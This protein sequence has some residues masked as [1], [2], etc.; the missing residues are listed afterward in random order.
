MN[1]NKLLT[2]I[3][4]ATLATSGI[5]STSEVSVVRAAS[6]QVTSAKQAIRISGQDRYETAAKVAASNWS[7]SDNV[8]LVSGEGYADAIS[9]SVL[10]KKLDA[11]V[12]LTNSKTLNSYAKAALSTLKA[13]NVYVIGGEASISKDVRDALKSTYSITE[14]GGANRYETN[15]AVAGKL[16]DLGVDATNAILVGGQGFSDALTAAS[17]ASSKGEIL[18][19]GSN[20]LSSIKSIENFVNSHKSK[21]TVIGTDLVINDNTYKAVNGANRV[22]G[23]KDRFDTNLKVLESFKS[24]IKGN[25]VYVANASGN[26][27]ADAL[28]ASALAGKNN[29]PLI[30][31]DREGSDATTNAINYLKSSLTSSSDIEVLGGTGVVPEVII[32]KIN[33]SIPSNNNPEPQA[34]LNSIKITSP[35]T[36]LDYTVGD[37]LDITGL[38]V[39]GTYSDNTTKYELIT[40]ANISGFDSSK[41]VDEQALT[42]TVDGKTTTYTIT[43][44]DSASQQPQPVQTEQTF[45]GYIT[46][47][48]DVAASLGEDTAYMIYMKLMAQ[49]GLGITFQ[50]DGKWVFYY[51][52]GNIATNNKS[53][54]DGKWTFDGTGSQLNAW[55]LVKAQ[56]ENGNPQGPVP[57]TVTGTLTENIQTNP[58]PDA[59]GQKYQVIAVKSITAN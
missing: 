31:V 52:D 42:I 26:D 59:D 40:E 54:A 29:S 38:K 9:A 1:K 37:K 22:A 10:A 53:G 44:K 3:L 27:Y 12:L 11:P 55:N 4:T 20:D 58:G 28:V 33:N 35:A 32:T 5:A 45:T 7:T 16:V 14:L 25:K 6:T 34:Q 24:D 48:D 47:E 36:K 57:V 46:T 17:I 23:G 30:L 41:A 18:L 13:K 51:F 50:K 2:L 49:S 15:A 39:T 56:V 8:V 19:L 21:V 43:V